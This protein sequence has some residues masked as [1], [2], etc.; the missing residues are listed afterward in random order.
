MG[1]PSGTPGTH[2]DPFPIY[3]ALVSTGRVYIPV[4]SSRCRSLHIWLW[5]PSDARAQLTTTG[6]F[7]LSRR[8][9]LLCFAPADLSPYFFVFLKH[10]PIPPLAMANNHSYPS[11]TD[12]NLSSG[13]TY[14][15]AHLAVQPSCPSSKHCP[16]PRRARSVVGRAAYLFSEQFPRQQRASHA[17][18]RAV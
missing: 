16:P 1:V 17:P 9:G 10:L 5:L 8:I 13:S 3:I 7:F 11:S 12:M 4:E 14:V 15:V 18:I 6:L 2:M